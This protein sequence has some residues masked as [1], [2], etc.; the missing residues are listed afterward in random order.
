MTRDER[1]YSLCFEVCGDKGVAVYDGI[2][3]GRPI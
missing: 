3:P 2:G 1:E